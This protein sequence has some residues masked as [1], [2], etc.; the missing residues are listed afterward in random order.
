[1]CSYSLT[2][3]VSPFPN[4]CERGATW[5]LCSYFERFFQIEII[6]HGLC[7]FTEMDITVRCITVQLIIIHNLL[8]H[9]L[10]GY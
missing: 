4:E 8:P 9:V 2:T 1:M 5:F 6:Q 3:K 10:S 7:L